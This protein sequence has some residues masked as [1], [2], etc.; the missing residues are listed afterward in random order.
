VVVVSVGLRQRAEKTVIGNAVNLAR[1]FCTHAR[2]GEILVDKE[3]TMTT[4]AAT[5]DPAWKRKRLGELLVDAGLIDEKTLDQA[6]EVQKVQKRRI[7]QILMEMGAADDVAIAR[8][9]SRQLRIPLVRLKDFTAPEE[10]IA[11]VSREMAENYLLLPLKLTNRQLTVALVNPLEFHAIDDL[12]FATGLDII[13]A[14]APESEMIAALG[15]H[16][17]KHDLERNFGAGSIIDGNFEVIQ[18]AEAEE[19]DDQ[20]LLKLTNQAPVVRL[21]NAILA[22]AIKLRASDVHI[23]PHKTSVVIR[24]RVDG[25]LREIM[26]TD[27]HVH[28]SLV[29]RIKI[30]AGMDISI[31]RK[32]QDGRARVRYNDKPYDLRV[33]TIPTTYGEKVT[34]RI[35]DSDSGKVRIEDLGFSADALV[36]I[37][38]AIQRPQGIIL[39][40]GPT[41]SGKSSTLYAC[42]NRVNAPGVNIITV[43]DPVEFEIEGITQVQINIKSGITFAAGLRSILRQDPDIVMVGEIRDSETAR[44]AFQA[45]QTGHLVLSTLHTNDA[46]AAVVRLL[47]LG[48]EDYLIAGSLLAVI[49]QR[50]VRKICSSCKQLDPVSPQMFD[51]IRA[52]LAGGPDPVFFKGNGCDECQFS[53]YAGRIGLFEVL[54]MSPALKTAISSRVSE[55]AIRRVVEREGYRPL[56]ADGIEKALA[57]LTTLAEVFRVAPPE[58]VVGTEAPIQKPASEPAQLP[59]DVF[60]IDSPASVASIRPKTI[61]LADD[62]EIV[63]KVLVNILESENYRILTAADGREALETARR[64]RPD[65]IITD[66]AMPR[67]NGIELVTQLR[68]RLATRYIP[69]IMLTARQEMDAEVEGIAAGADDYLTKPVNPRRLLARVGRFLKRS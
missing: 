43:E 26:K 48:V 33:S 53:G 39:V 29:S 31:R 6:L 69:I 62:S 17:P 15:R 5:P 58:P 68:A 67:M 64:E 8:V 1:R 18:S 12:R 14:V 19:E 28:T 41:G 65:L 3:T 32:P 9:L 21:A 38:E 24:Y 34:I 7:G 59:N 4:Q 60:P 54:R 66:L 56:P 52:Y 22:D 61:L 11:L 30:M 57:G 2:P 13:V 50:L 55:V 35:L 44:I 10:I 20:E 40:T 51:H 16:Y 23:E 49:G 47:D 36:T 25:I 46:P 45:A 27:R 42:L 63:I 37:L